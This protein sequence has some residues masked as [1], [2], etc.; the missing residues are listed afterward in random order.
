MNEEA[1]EYS[2]NLFSD[3]GYNGTIDDYK[4]LI[5]SNQEALDESYRIFSE[6]GYNGT[7]DD[8]STLL[9]VGKQTGVAETGAAVTPTGEAPESME[10]ESA[11]GS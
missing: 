2:F 9:G 10:L 3:N 11:N 8:Y 7:I 4:A 1:L 5:S 6:G